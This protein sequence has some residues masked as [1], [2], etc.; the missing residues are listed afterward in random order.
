MS[1]WLVVTAA[2]AAGLLAGCGPESLGDPADFVQPT[3]AVM[4]FENRA[5]FPLAWNLG[6]GMADILVDRLMATGRYHV[7]ERPELQSVLNELRLQ[8]SGVT[9]DQRRARLGRLK[10]VQY[11]IKGTVTDFGHVT[12]ASAWART[13]SLG[14]AGSRAEA[15]MGM[16]FHV[17]DV[18]SGEIIHSRSLEESV[19]TNEV[20][21]KA[22]YSDVALGGRVFYRTPLGRATAGVMDRAVRQITAA[23]ASRPWRL[24]IAMVAEDGTII[25]NGGA[26]RKVLVGQEYEVLEMG[27]AIIDPDT[28]DVLDRRAAKAVGRLRIVEVR[29]RYSVAEVL[30]G[31]AARL[32]VGQS[33]R[34][35]T[36]PPPAP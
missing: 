35:L 34:L 25:L 2:V 21:V 33:C 23:I 31:A 29:Q 30:D 1:R 14:I 7:I 4:K 6:G 16:T 12:S 10:N 8:T 27:Q 5:P 9:R 19:S 3:V 20:A 11:L 26:Y 13:A 36:P 22:R 24:K 28:G 15:I 17:V 32:R 18:E